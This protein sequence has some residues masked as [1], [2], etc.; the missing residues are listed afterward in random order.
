MFRRD[1][2]IQK[3]VLRTVIADQMKE[4]ETDVTGSGFVKRSALATVSSY[5][6]TSALVVKGVRRCGKSTLARQIM[7]ERFGSDFLY[8]NFDDERAAGFTADDFQALMETLIESS[9]DKKNVFFDEIQNVRGWELF[10]NR[11]M[12]QGYKV[13]ITGSNANLLSRELGTHLTGRHVDVELYP[14]SF[15]EFLKSQKADI[16][17]KGFYST[18]QKAAL[19]KKF[20]EYLSGGGMPEA[21]VLGNSAMLT[22]VLNDIIQKDI[23]VRYGIRKP[24][25][26]KSVMRFL[27][28][29]AGN[30]ITYRSIRNNFG[31]RSANTVQKYV[32]CA[33]ETYLVFTVRRF[34]K[35]IKKFDKN[36]RKVYCVD[37]GI[38]SKNTPDFMEKKGAMLENAV[39]VQLK[40][41]GKEFFYFRGKG[42]AEADF[43]IPSEKKAIQVCYELND[44]DRQREARGLLEAAREAGAS[45]LLI[46]TLEQEGTEEDGR[47]EIRPAWQW[48]LENEPS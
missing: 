6:G 29:N 12:R 15:S 32:E 43:V 5:S 41:L 35:K 27:I 19:S 17:K 38:M 3:S 30:M 4:I 21:V 48:L 9:G 22:Q 20:S 1:S 8:F 33:E 37:N 2:M 31:I 28:A 10:V 7:K 18:G 34:E 23:V 42:G 11:I 40:R 47:I 14:F 25:E 16:P 45:E 39:A 46:L 36:Q 44:G 24:A 13:F 26:L